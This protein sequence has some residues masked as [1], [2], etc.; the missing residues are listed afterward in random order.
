MSRRST[1][2]RAQE[3]LALEQEKQ[4]KQKRE[5]KSKKEQEKRDRQKREHEEWDQKFAGEP[6]VAF[7]PRNKLVCK[8]IDFGLDQESAIELQLLFD[9]KGGLLGKMGPSALWRYRPCYVK[10]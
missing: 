6:I 3:N 2:S 4:Q 7:C 1:R 9:F 5:E 8:M 10:Q